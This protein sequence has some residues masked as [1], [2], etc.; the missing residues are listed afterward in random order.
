M[1]WEIW[2]LR[3]GSSD[4]CSSLGFVPVIA[5]WGL[6]NPFTHH[7][8]FQS[9]KHELHLTRVLFSSSEQSLAWYIFWVD[10]VFAV[11]TLEWVSLIVIFVVATSFLAPDTRP[12]WSSI[13]TEP[14]RR[15]NPSKHSICNSI[16][17]L[18]LPFG[19]W[20][21]RCAFQVF[22]VVEQKERRH[23]HLAAG[24]L[25]KL[26]L[27]K[28]WQQ[29]TETRLLSCGGCIVIRSLASTQ[30]LDAEIEQTSL[31]PFVCI[32]AL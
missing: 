20:I 30:E 18:F 11:E 23:F 14:H 13:N 21:W 8:A 32:Q 29:W 17:V 24:D 9:Q 7:S 25:F 1:K 27:R 12:L 6:P 4:I 16:S 31:L 10:V 26:N 28:N 22:F 3:F 5:F 2:P 19:S 15:T